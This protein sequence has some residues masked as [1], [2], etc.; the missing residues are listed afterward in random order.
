[1]QR[2][3][4]NLCRFTGICEGADGQNRVSRNVKNRVSGNC[5]KVVKF[6]REKYKELLRLLMVKLA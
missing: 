3:R 5:A 4:G 2:L 1:M 6:G